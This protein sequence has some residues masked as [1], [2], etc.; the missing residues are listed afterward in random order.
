MDRVPEY[1][2]YC[3][4]VRSPPFSIKGAERSGRKRAARDVTIFCVS[5]DAQISQGN[6]ALIS[7][8]R[9]KIHRK[10]RGR[11]RE[12]EREQNMSVEST[13]EIGKKKK[14]EERK[15][16]ARRRMGQRNKSRKIRS[17]PLRGSLRACVRACRVGKQLRPAISR[18]R[19]V[20]VGKKKRRC[21]NT[22]AC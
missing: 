4:S 14:K 3:L 21:T 2:K 12:A 16:R 17:R 9:M 6:G 1:N 18:A 8:C 20:R 22:I 5:L 7:H 10:P 13:G 15:R 19:I 11:D